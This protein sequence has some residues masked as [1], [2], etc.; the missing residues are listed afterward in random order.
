MIVSGGR[1]RAVRKTDF[2]I[3]VNNH[4]VVTNRNTGKTTDKNKT[5]TVMYIN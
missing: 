1:P 4:E 5:N 3:F 2:F